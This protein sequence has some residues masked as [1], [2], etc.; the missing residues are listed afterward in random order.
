MKKFLALLICLLLLLPVAASAEGWIADATL[1]EEELRLLALMNGDERHGPYDFRAP[2]GATHLTLTAWVL[3]DGQWAEYLSN[4]AALTQ[5]QEET[6]VTITATQD[7]FG[8]WHAVVQN[9]RN[10]TIPADGRFYIDAADLPNSLWLLILPDG[11]D[12]PYNIGN[13]LEEPL[14]LGTLHCY[15]RTFLQPERD[16]IHQQQ[17]SA[18]L[19]EQVVIVVY[20]CYREGNPGAPAISDF[21]T[22]EAFAVYDYAFAITATFTS[23]EK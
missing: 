9:P 20:G 18:A 19:D 15:Q 13:H 17:I 16:G 23:E 7:T 1:T 14:A 2:E 3:E 6:S 21:H 22:P 8:T 5:P 12:Y 10:G 11:V 4:T